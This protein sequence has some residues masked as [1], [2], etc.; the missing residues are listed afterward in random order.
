M[1]KCWRQANKMPEERL[2]ILLAGR[3]SGN[4]NED[5]FQEPEFVPR[6][7]RG[8]SRHPTNKKGR[9]TA[10]TIP[11]WAFQTHTMA[12]YPEASALDAA[13]NLLR[14]PLLVSEKSSAA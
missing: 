5:S 2:G 10:G 3:P 11:P 9:T 12:D 1:S 4:K 7:G 6:G 14:V 13:E 8:S